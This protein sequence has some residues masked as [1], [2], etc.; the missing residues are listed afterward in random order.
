MPRPIFIGG[1][2][3]KYVTLEVPEEDAWTIRVLA[4]CARGRRDFGD[5]TSEQ[6]TRLA[7]IAKQLISRV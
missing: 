2:S 7:E 5:L 6:C 4:E 1:N 3:A